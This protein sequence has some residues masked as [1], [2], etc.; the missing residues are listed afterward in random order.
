MDEAQEEFALLTHWF[1]SHLLSAHYIPALYQEKEIKVWA[2]GYQYYLWI[3]DI[4]QL[5]VQINYSICHL[6]QDATIY[7]NISAYPISR[8]LEPV[9]LLRWPGSQIL[10]ESICTCFFYLELLPTWNPPCSPPL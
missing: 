7:L 9:L 6:F 8:L 4:K 3:L 2:K 1:H 5:F 10:P